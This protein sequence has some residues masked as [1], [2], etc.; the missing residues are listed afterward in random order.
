MLRFYTK[1]VVQR[2]TVCCD[3][4]HLDKSTSDYIRNTG[5]QGLGSASAFW[6]RICVLKSHLRFEIASAFWSRICV[7]KSHLRFEIASAFWNRSCRSNAAAFSEC[8]ISS[9]E[10]IIDSEKRLW[11]D[12][13]QAI[14]WTRAGILFIVPFCHVHGCSVT[15]V[16]PV[17]KLG[18]LKQPS[19]CVLRPNLGDPKIT[20]LAI[21][22]LNVACVEFLAT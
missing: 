16:Q 6:N 2:C 10:L 12:R 18:S 14:I 19:W 4:R 8:D 1:F 22:C 21:S 17:P 15:W 7:L 9:L 13:R 5:T 20:C 11:P 3:R